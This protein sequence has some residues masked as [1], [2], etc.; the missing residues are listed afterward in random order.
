MPKTIHFKGL[1]GI[2]A[3]AAIAVLISHIL[4]DLPNFGLNKLGTSLNMASYGVTMFFTLSGFLITYL[5]LAEKSKSSENK[6]NIKNFYIRRILRIWPLYYLYLILCIGAYFYFSVEYDK[7]QLVFYVFL[8]AN[9]PLILQQSLPFIGHLWSIAVEEQFYLWWPWLSKVKTQKI[10]KTTFAL[11]IL[12]LLLKYV[13]FIVKIYFGYETPIIAIT[14]TRFYC[15]LFGCV[16]AILYF[17]KSKIIRYF[18]NIYFSVFCWIIIFLSFIGVFQVSS[19]LIDHEIISI[20]TIGVI[21]TQIHRKNMIV[22]LDQ[23][24]FNFF[25]KISYGLYVYH[26]LII[27]LYIKLFG[28]FKEDYWYN[29]LVVI[30]LIIITTILVAYLSFHFFE[31]KFITLKDRYSTVKST[32]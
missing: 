22:D 10:F 4:G 6:I 28:V 3:I 12:L 30:S 13:L 18:A 9:V 24:V 26:P 17:K 32:A 7:E 11:L 27:F 31:K 29:Y 8:L 20:I 1:N 15:M 21:M 2:R 25:G 5:L 23:K 14:V 16:A 19:T